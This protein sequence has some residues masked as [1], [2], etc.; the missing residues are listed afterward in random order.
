VRRFVRWVRALLALGRE[1]PVVRRGDTI[2]IRGL[3]GPIE[4][5]RD[6][7]FASPAV[8]GT[9]EQRRA[10]FKLVDDGLDELSQSRRTRN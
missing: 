7:Y 5:D 3:R 8:H 9:A 2:V 6:A 4:V 10:F 1:E